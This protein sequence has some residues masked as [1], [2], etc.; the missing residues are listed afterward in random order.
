MRSA[1]GSPFT[2]RF[3]L[4]R[5]TG[6]W[7]K[8]RAASSIRRAAAVDPT[9]TRHRDDAVRA[10]S[11]PRRGRGPRD[12]RHLRDEHPG[13][14]SHRRLL[15]AGATSTCFSS[16][17]WSCRC[18]AARTR[19]PAVFYFDFVRLRRI[20]A[21][22]RVSAAV[23]PQA[24]V[25]DAGHHAVLLVAWRSSLALFVLPDVPF[26]FLLALLPL[27]VVRSLIG[28]YQ[29]R[30][31]AEGQFRTLNATIVL[32]AVLVR[33]RVDRRQSPLGSRPDHRGDDRAAHRPHQPA[34]LRG[35]HSRAAHAAVAAATGSTRWPPNL[36]P[37]VSAGSPIPEWIDV[38]AEVGRRRR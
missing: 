13:L 30:L 7:P 4:Y 25:D 3:A 1:S 16:S 28:A 36:Q 11:A 38:A 15:G 33:A 18:S 29:I 17:T 34:A 14:R 24:A 9:P 35:P 31:F 19:P 5:L 20:P 32:S 22:P 2:S 27:F 8:F 21:L 23:L 37:C 6:L 12:C 26:S 10:R